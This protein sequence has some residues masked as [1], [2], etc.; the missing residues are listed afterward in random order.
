MSQD[1]RDTKGLSQLYH[2][3]SEPWV[4]EVPGGAPQYL[5]RA[6]PR[7]GAPLIALPPTAESALDTW[8]NAR[9]STRAFDPRALH[10]SDLARVLRSGY[11]ALGP[12]PIGGGQTILRRPVPSAG[13]LYSLEIYALV[14]NVTGLSSGIYA[15]DPVGDGLLTL[16][17]DAWQDDAAAAFLS[18]SSVSS[19][20][21]LICIAAVFER[22]QAKYGP[23]GYRY[24]LMEAGHVGQMLSLSA[25][26]A[27]LSTL[28]LGGFHDTRL[29]TLLGLD[30][31]EEAVVYAMALGHA[32]A[33]EHPP[34]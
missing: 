12:D 17:T 29:N 14:Q 24:V 7:P 1:I 18:W 22:T 31:V 8:A 28:F 27:G 30:G 10:L 23:R 3:N 33:A 21:V 34:T 9:R 11:R 6:K 15:Y 4:N 19:A 32:I 26:T 5:H 16:S 13:G 25:E 20:P 2:L